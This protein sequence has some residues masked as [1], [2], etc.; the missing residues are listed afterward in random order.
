MLEDVAIKPMKTD[1]IVWRCLHDGPLSAKTIDQWDPEINI[2]WEQYRRRNM[3]LLEGLIEE[4]GTC[5]MLAWDHDQ[6][7]GFLFFVPKVV[8]L[9]DGAGSLCLQQSPPG[10]PSDDFPRCRLPSSDAIDDKT[11]VVRCLMTGS[12]KLTENPYQRRGIGTRMARALIQ[13]AIEH[14]W[15]GIEARSFE[16]IAS[17]YAH[18]G[19]AGRTFWEKLGF[20]IVKAGT[21]PAFQNEN[22]FVRQLREEAIAAGLDPE[23]FKNSYTMRLVLAE[24]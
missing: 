22:D 6:V 11:L 19:N 10:G 3:P 2:P 12:P 23:S 15:Q 16:D 18:T 5:M 20:R 8:L 17:L 7:V 9:M 13:W 14:G 1:F 4:Y 21:N 24:K